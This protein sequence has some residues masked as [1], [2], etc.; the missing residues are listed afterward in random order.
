MPKPVTYTDELSDYIKKNLKKS[1][2]KE[3]LKWALVTQGH[4][5]T[6]IEKAFKRVEEEMARQAPILKTKPTINHQAYDHQ[7]NPLPVKR[8]FWKK[9]FGN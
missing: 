5:K 4:S 9:L 2:T 3:S 1:Y 6:E 7:D 8:P